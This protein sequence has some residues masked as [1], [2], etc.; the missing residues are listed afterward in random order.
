[1][2]NGMTALF[3]R[4]GAGHERLSGQDA[5]FLSFEGPGRPMHL[6]ALAFVPAEKWLGSDGELD[7]A[8]LR[9]TFVQRA[10]AVPALGKQ[11]SR[12]PLTGWPVWV[13]ADPARMA[14]HVEVSAPVA[15][16]GE[17]GMIA[18]TAMATPLNRGRP[19]WRL[20]I[21][22]GIDD[23]RTF[24]LVFLAHHGLIDG[25]A[26]IDLLAQLLD[27]D[28]P[29]RQREAPGLGVATSRQQLLGAEVLRWLELPTV[30]MLRG[31]G[32]ATDGRRMRRALRRGQAL[33]RTC[34]RLLTPGPRTVLRSDNDGRRHVAWFS[35]DERP[36]RFARRRL[37][38]TPN[39]IVLAAV[40]EAI[41]EMG[42]SEGHVPFRKMR[43]A[44]PVSLR[45]R[46]QRYEAGNRIGLVL[47]PL[48]VRERNAGRRVSRIHGHTSVQ[49][50]RGDAEG[51]EVLCE[52]TSWTGRWSQR[53]LH[54][55]AGTLHS[56]GVLVTNVP[57]PSRA[58]TLGGA[59]LEEIYP[60]V[61]LFGGQA[62]SVGVIRYGATLH[63]GV[64]SSWRDRAMVDAFASRLEDAFA[65]LTRAIAYEAAATRSPAP[66]AG[67]ATADS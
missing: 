17:A 62:V 61:P 65:R 50:A 36:V 16:R 28:G 55:L 41:G 34:V 51:Y 66:S 1:M 64:L 44:I 35:I 8:R 52:L 18:E 60:L 39:D 14:D 25:I 9:E 27:G 10:R 48:E 3:A 58:Y 30:V 11:L 47:T 6:G 22:P 57:G 2:L 24:G 37:G 63:V 19:L 67:T 56:Y 26:G 43:A 54:W 38:G 33:V 45:A 40:A 23:G 7:V 32:M 42:G 49:K 5:A 59:E 46:S 12:A 29:A 31:L 4:T 13:R 20:V 21:V 15:T 53:L